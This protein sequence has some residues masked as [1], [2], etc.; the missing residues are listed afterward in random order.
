MFAVTW[1]LLGLVVTGITVG[2]ITSAL[3][4]VVQLVDMKSMTIYGSKVK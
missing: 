4:E 3:A 2:A 1:T